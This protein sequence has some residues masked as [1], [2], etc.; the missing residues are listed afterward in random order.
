L[1]VLAAG[2]IFAA[3]FD[4]KAKA[5]L[6]ETLLRNSETLIREFREA[7]AQLI[8][9]HV[10]AD[11]PPI[12]AIDDAIVDISKFF[13]VSGIGHVA[14]HGQTWSCPVSVDG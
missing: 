10:P 3:A 1:G 4:G 8:A 5:K 14:S 9:A 13:R 2:V 6:D 7:R 11:S 12:K